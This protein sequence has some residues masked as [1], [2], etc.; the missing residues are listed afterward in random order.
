MHFSIYV[1]DPGA[2]P[3]TLAELGLPGLVDG[4]FCAASA[5]PDGSRGV[6][7]SWSPTVGKNIGRHVLGYD[8]SKQTWRPAAAMGDLPAS[9]YWVGFQNG[10]PVT[11]E[12]L[13]R[14]YPFRGHK[15]VLGDGNEW[16]FAAEREIPYQVKLADDG[17]W[18]CHPQR[19]FDEFCQAA[20]EWKRITQS[21][22]VGVVILEA[23]EFVRFSLSINYRL[24]P[25]IEDELNLWTTSNS[26]TICEAFIGILESEGVFK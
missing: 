11:P 23:L 8:A 25:E 17:S 18:R 1:P 10:S 4:A 12:D 16:W 9:R 14:S 24:T 15:S 19:Q 20:R 26:G 7:F 6:V 5:G 13:Q 21:C 22:N 2:K 3:E